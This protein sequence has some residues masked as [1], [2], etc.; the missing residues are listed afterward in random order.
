MLA[1]RWCG[2]GPV[3]ADVERFWVRLLTDKELR[4]RFFADPVT[5]ATEHGLSPDERDAMLAVSRQDLMTAGRSYAHKAA[6]KP[7]PQAWWTRLA[8]LLRRVG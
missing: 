8:R 4:A 3:Q 1:P 5:V 2:A 7:K 6:M